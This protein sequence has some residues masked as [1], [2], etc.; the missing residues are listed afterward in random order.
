MWFLRV[1]WGWNIEKLLEDFSWN[2]S[3]FCAWIK[4]VLRIEIY[5]RPK[6]GTYVIRFVATDEPW[7]FQQTKIWNSAKSCIFNA[8]LCVYIYIRRSDIHID[9]PK[10][11]LPNISHQ[12]LRL[13]ESLGLKILKNCSKVTRPLP[14]PAVG[15]RWSIGIHIHGRVKWRNPEQEKHWFQEKSRGRLVTFWNLLIFE[16]FALSYWIIKGKMPIVW[17]SGEFLVL[18]KMLMNFRNT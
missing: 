17:V 15:W 11:K 16:N 18:Q 6:Q 9:I 8:F 7:Q 14:S 13:S 10:K 12:N 1:G 5:Q 2:N 3:E 4:R